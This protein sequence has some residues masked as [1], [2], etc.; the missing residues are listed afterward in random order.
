M[1]YLSMIERQ[2]PTAS[3]YISLESTRISV[4]TIQGSA[5]LKF[6]DFIVQDLPARS[7]I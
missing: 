2:L 5:W 7:N 6:L 3:A 1:A 4:A